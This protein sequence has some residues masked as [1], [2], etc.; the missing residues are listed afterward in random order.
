MIMLDLKNYSVNN[1]VSL[2]AL[3]STRKELSEKRHSL[4]DEC[5][6]YQKKTFDK[7]YLKNPEYIKIQ[8]TLKEDLEI[9]THISNSINLF[10]KYGN[11]SGNVVL[12]D[13]PVLNNIIS[14]EKATKKSYNS[15]K[16]KLGVLIIWNRITKTSEN[17]G[18]DEYVC[19][20]FCIDDAKNHKEVENRFQIASNAIYEISDYYSI[21]DYVRKGHRVL[22]GYRDENKKFFETGYIS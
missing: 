11:I 13:R 19:E 10:Y 18:I 14:F 1:E 5:I 21:N 17:Q 20:D 9:I 16:H 6:Y 8:E 4:I 15:S 7:S 3:L 22:Y 2:N 12:D